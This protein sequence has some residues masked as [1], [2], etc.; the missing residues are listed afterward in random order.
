M[1]ATFPLSV[2]RTLSLP[3]SSYL[4]V[5]CQ[6]AVTFVH[7]SV[8]FSSIFSGVSKRQLH[9]NSNSSSNRNRGR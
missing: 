9:S 7:T 8:E 4:I 3:V 6:H 2:Y 5:E 1:K